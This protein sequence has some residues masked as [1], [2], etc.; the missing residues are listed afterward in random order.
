MASARRA[1]RIPAGAPCGAV[2]PSGLRVHCGLTPHA[3]RKSS[4]KTLSP[5]SRRLFAAS[6]GQ[7]PMPSCCSYRVTLFSRCSIPIEGIPSTDGAFGGGF[8]R[9]SADGVTILARSAGPLALIPFRYPCKQGV[10]LA[11]GA[12]FRARCVDA[13]SFG[14]II[15]NLLV[16]FTK[17]ASTARSRSSEKR[18][19]CSLSFAGRWGGPHRVG[20]VCLSGLGTMTTRDYPW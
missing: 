10:R 15:A 12:A 14:H 1:G 8:R 16:C 18:A 11:S 13:I 3:S 17:A 5:L 6:F 19:F 7:Q 9:W 4:L 2:E 20:C